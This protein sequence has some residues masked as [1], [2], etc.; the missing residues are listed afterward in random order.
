MGNIGLSKVADSPTFGP[1]WD[2]A[3]KWLEAEVKHLGVQCGG[4]IGPGPMMTLKTAAASLAGALWVYEMCA[5]DNSPVLLDKF[6]NLQQAHAANWSLAKKE[7]LAD[8]AR[9]RA[10]A[11]NDP[12][13]A[14]RNLVSEDDD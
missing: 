13:A 12:Y 11:D 4:F 8:A 7:A 14:F 2:T 6:K 10:S 3:L 5:I 1:H 9:R